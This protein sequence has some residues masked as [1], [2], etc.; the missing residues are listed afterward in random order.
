[1][2]NN[3][4]SNNIRKFCVECGEPFTASNNLVRLCPVCAE[5][6]KRKAK[7]KQ[8]NYVRERSQRLGITN[9]SIYKTDKEIL[10]AMAS[11]EKTTM[12]EVLKKIL[13]QGI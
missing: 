2:N 12:A 13:A 10:L 3:I 11:K 7:E 8:R 9:I 5:E 4:V 6:H 1:M